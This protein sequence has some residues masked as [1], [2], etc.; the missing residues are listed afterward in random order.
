MEPVAAIASTPTVAATVAAIA[1]NLANFNT[2][3]ATLEASR[4]ADE[5]PDQRRADQCL[6]VLPLAMNTAASAD[7]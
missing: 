5:M 1:T 6:S 4:N 7:D 2:S 3:L